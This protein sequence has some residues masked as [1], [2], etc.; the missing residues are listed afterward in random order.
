MAEKTAETLPPKEESA[1]PPPVPTPQAPRILTSRSV[2]SHPDAHA[3]VLDMVLL[4]N[5]HIDWLSWLPDTLFSEIEQ[6]FKTS[7]A[8]VNK[9]KILATQTLHV[10][11][12]FWDQWEIFEK[13]LWALNG[14]IP[15]TDV[16]QPPDLPILFAG[17][18]IADNVRK[19]TFSEEVGR[20]CAAVFLNENVFY[21]PEPLKFCQ[22]YITQP[23]Y[24]CKDC[25]KKASALPPFDGLCSSCAGHFEHEHPFSFKP[26]PDLLKN[27]V[28]RNL[29]IGVTYNPTPVKNRFEELDSMPAAKVAG[30]LRE[31]P[32]DIQAAKLITAIDFMK[33]RSQQ[34]AEQLGSLRSWL[35]DA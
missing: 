32:E 20:Y 25:G 3:V 27:G 33:Y 12:A 18:D 15:R 16:I 10:I 1:E 23:Y 26:D 9:L 4:K 14:M 22:D 28:G 11:D 34:L 7:I 35:E 24:H 29:E 30:A 19:E 5:F 8:E 17:V 21:A 31:T 2:F 6:T 13:T